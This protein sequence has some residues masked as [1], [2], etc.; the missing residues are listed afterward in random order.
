ML[1]LL[2]QRQLHFP[3][4]S[5]YHQHRT[6]HELIHSFS[7]KGDLKADRS[8]SSQ[9]PVFFFLFPRDFLPGADSKV[10][11]RFIWNQSKRC[12]CRDSKA[13]YSFIMIRQNKK[14]TGLNELK[15][16]NC[17]QMRA[18]QADSPRL[19]FVTPFF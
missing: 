19:S 15:T 8:A 1:V 6:K 5:S 14:L 11:A 12:W 2:S 16:Q 13:F 18:C 9:P 17:G 4:S 3:Q 10:K 7:L